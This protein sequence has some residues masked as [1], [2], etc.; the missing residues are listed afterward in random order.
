MPEIIKKKKLIRDYLL[1]AIPQNKLPEMI[2]VLTGQV[3]NLLFGFGL[4]KIISTLGT[5]VFGEYSLLMTVAALLGM[6]FYGPV[7]QGFLRYYYQYENE[8]GA[9]RFVRLIYKIL[10]NFSLIILSLFVL[11]SF[12]MAY[13]G[14]WKIY[15]FI[16]YGLF[17]ILL[18]LTEFYNSFLNLLRKRKENSL[19]QAIE[20]VIIILLL[21]LLLFLNEM[22]LPGALASYSTVMI[23]FIIIKITY[24]KKFLPVEENTSTD[25]FQPDRKK[26]Y[27]NLFTYVLPFLIWGLTGWLQLNSEKWIMA[28]L[29]STKDVGIYAVMMSLI[30]AF[31]IVPNTT[32]SDFAT[33]IIFRKF[34]NLSDNGSVKEGIK[35]VFM[36]VI[37]SVIILIFSVLITFFVGKY[38]ILLI[39]SSDF[40]TYY[41][42]LPWLVTGAGMF[43]IGQTFCFLGMGLNK[44]KKY[45]FPK[46]LVGILSP[47]LNYYFINFWGINGVA[48]STL[49]IG[50][51]YLVH[52]SLINLSMLK[53][54]KVQD[55]FKN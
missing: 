10:A 2:W 47:L 38:L 23:L 37:L 1:S 46:I 53:E 45:L 49:M 5:A 4:V 34:S 30:S 51:I 14:G 17:V 7:T 22:T 6:I 48:Y 16:L 28:E 8:S 3:I 11:L 21:L 25:S 40:T 36:S 18:K 15:T 55:R 29:L 33:P 54:L 41:Y 50:L 35:N 39:S 52:I 12:Y 9:N 43:Y 31:I 24:L 27:S 32:I 42:L 19:L 13:S 26:M 44:P 20:K